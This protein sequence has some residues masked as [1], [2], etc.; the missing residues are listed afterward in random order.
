MKLELRSVTARHATTR[1]ESADALA[2]LSLG[3]ESGEVVAVIGPSGAGKTTLLEVLAC[4]RPPSQGSLEV[5]GAD[6]WQLPRRALQRLRGRLI[7][8]PQVPPLPPR[9]RVVTAVLAGRLPHEGLW[10]SLRSLFYPVDIPRAERALAGFDVADKLFDRVDRLSGGERQRVGLAR[11]LVSEASLLLVDEPLS[12]LDPTRSQHAIETLT[13][14]ARARGATLVATLHHVEMA[15]AHFPRIV[16]LRD[17]ALAFDLPAADVTPQHLQA[18]YA[19][20][21]H[22]LTGPAL[23]PDD[24]FPGGPAPVAMHCR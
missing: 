12:A 16:G 22:E 3:V 5:G 14:A 17:G 1:R 13:A 2:G 15:L 23:A 4:S 18:L 21:L 20:H 6:P 11:A 10:T 24:A 7:L 19:Q 8:V 9:Q